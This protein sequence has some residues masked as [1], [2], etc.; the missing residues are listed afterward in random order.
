[1]KFKFLYTFFG[2][3]LMAFFTMSNSGGVAAVQEKGRTNAPGDAGFCGQCHSSG[4]FAP[5]VSVALSLD[6]APV[7]DYVA[8][9][10]YDVTVTV[11]GTTGT[12]SGYG[13]QVVALLDNES[14][15]NTFFPITGGT[16]TVE[17]GAG[18]QAGRQYF[19]HFGTSSGNVFEGEWTAP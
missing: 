12:P 17:L 7:T 2:I 13:F 15:V 4:A 16:E 10:T 3:A 8:G 11:D 9:T 6:G 5:T 1:M 14:S 18:D 19:E